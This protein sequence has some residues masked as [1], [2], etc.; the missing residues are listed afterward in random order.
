M[1]FKNGVLIL[2]L[3]HILALNIRHLALDKSAVH[4]ISKSKTKVL[5][6]KSSVDIQKKNAAF[7]NQQRE[8]LENMMQ[9]ICRLELHTLSLFLP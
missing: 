9:N 5:A 3:I 1:L 7:N 6:N 2:R 8:N 4:D